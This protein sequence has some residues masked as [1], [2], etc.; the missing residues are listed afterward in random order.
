MINRKYTDGN[1]FEK[2][3]E[4]FCLKTLIITVKEKS[5][6]ICCFFKH[7]TINKIMNNYKLYKQFLSS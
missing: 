6:R 3:D 2:L 7:E 4:L 5:L 1:E